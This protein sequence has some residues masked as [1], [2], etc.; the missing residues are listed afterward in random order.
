LGDGAALVGEDFDDPPLQ[1]AA[2]IESVMATASAV[3]SS[4]NL[5]CRN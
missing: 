3:V 2:T 1:L 5:R 4:R